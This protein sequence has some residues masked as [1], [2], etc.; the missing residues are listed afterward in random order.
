MKIK[1]QRQGDLL[2]ETIE[3]IE[4]KGAKF[5]KDGILARG[6]STGHAHRINPLDLTRCK[7]YELSEPKRI[8]IEAFESVRVI[9]EEHGTNILPRGTYE[10]LQQREYSPEAIHNV[11]D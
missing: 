6:E 5:L 7:V 11:A 10:V 8:I 4:T 3:K 9:H 1:Q 2:F